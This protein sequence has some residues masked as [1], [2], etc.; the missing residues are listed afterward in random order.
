[1]TF[2]YTPPAKPASTNVLDRFKAP[3]YFEWQSFKTDR[4]K[5]AH[6]FITASTGSGKSSLATYLA[7]QLAEPN[8]VTIAVAPHWQRGD[9]NTC[10]TVIGSGRNY[11]TSALPYEEKPLKN[12]DVKIIGEVDVSFRD[13]LSGC[14]SPTVCQFM[15][16][17]VNEMDKRFK[18]VD[19]VYSWVANNDPFINVILDEYPAYGSREGVKECL[20]ELIRE[21]RKAGIRLIVLAQGYEVAS[22]GIEGEGSLRENMTYIRLGDWASTHATVQLNKYKPG[23]NGYT[24][25]ADVLEKFTAA[26]P[27]MVEDAPSFVPELS[28]ERETPPST[29]DADEV[30][31]LIHAR[32]DYWDELRYTNGWQLTAHLAFA[33]SVIEVCGTVCE[34]EVMEATEC[35]EHDATVSIGLARRLLLYEFGATQLRQ[36]VQEMLTTDKPITARKAQDR[37]RKR[38]TFPGCPSVDDVRTALNDLVRQGLAVFV[39]D[40]YISTGG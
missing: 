29:S 25:W 13:V 14:V 11:G 28:A 7:E 27:A 1:M 19:G 5:Y 6:L 18:L 22:L 39:D 40:A 10:D 24:F 34:T 2:V 31:G 16:S 15:R 37:L 8:S 9:F 23:T 30:W 35:S 12:D 38:K 36:A 32:L 3:Q 33:L 20:K 4:S 26:R 17:M 21:A